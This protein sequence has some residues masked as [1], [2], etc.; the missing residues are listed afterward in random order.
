MLCCSTQAY[1]IIEKYSEVLT[2]LPN[3]FS[4]TELLVRL[5]QLSF[6][7]NFFPPNVSAEAMIIY[8]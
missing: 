2:R 5:L 8:S 1:F 7:L 4:A 3:D 6:V